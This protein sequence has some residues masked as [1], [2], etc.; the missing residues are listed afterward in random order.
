MKRKELQKNEIGDFYWR[1][2]NLIPEDASLIETLEKNTAEICHFL[3]SLPQEKWE[4]RY[5][6]EKWSI[7]E[8]IQHIID[9]ERVFQYRALSIARGEEKPLPGFDHDQYVKASEAGTRKGAELVEEFRTLRKA[10]IWMYRNFNEKM[11]SRQGT[12]NGNPASPRAIA[13]VMAGHALHHKNII[14]ER[15]L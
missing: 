12:V 2:I 1:Y 10:A 7:L 13:F 3:L 6:N 14:N 8:V 5:E 9:T 4:Y 11:L 15:Y